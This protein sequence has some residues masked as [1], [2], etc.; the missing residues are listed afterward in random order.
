MGAGEAELPA[1]IAE[2]KAAKAEHQVP[3]A[4]PVAVDIKGRVFVSALPVPEDLQAFDAVIYCASEPPHTNS[5]RFLHLPT[6]SNPKLASKSLAT[7]LLRMDAFI[8]S[9]LSEADNTFPRTLVACPTG[10]D[11]AIGVVLALLVKYP[12][13]AAT[14][15]AYSPREVDKALIRSKLAQIIAAKPDA[16]PSRKTLNAVN[17]F[18]M[19][20]PT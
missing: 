6:P 7:N 3:A 4:E 20:R 13:L 16:N 19:G 5:S 9:L 17:G 15:S 2:L 18:L 14:A 11:I 8:L 10:N 12:Q 1:L